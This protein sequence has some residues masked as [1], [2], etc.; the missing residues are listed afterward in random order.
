MKSIPPLSSVHFLSGY[1]NPTKPQ[2]QAQHDNSNGDD[3][4]IAV[5]CRHHLKQKNAKHHIIITSSGKVRAPC[6]NRS[7]KDTAVR[8]VP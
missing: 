7:I 2:T 6:G 4:N 3:E 5:L 1:N 8:M